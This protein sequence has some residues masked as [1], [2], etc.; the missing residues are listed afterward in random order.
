VLLPFILAI[1]LCGVFCLIPLTMYL[2]WLGAIT[3]RDRPTLVTGPWDFAGV[4]FAL[5]G[6]AIFGAGLVLSF[7]QA[8]FRFWMRGNFEALRGAWAQERGSWVLLVG[9][10]LVV[11]LSWAALVLAARRRSLVVYNIEPAALETL[12]TEVF[13]QLNRPLERR[14]K[15]WVGADPLFE[16][17]T[18]EGGHTATLRW[19][20]DDERLFEEV[21]RM[22]RTALASHASAENPADGWVRSA[23]YGCGMVVVCCLGLL[24]YGLTL[25]AR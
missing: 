3:R 22:L 6:F 16:L 19:V 24:V 15:L 4:L 12:L 17:D 1:C 14:G 23:A 25:M 7:A 20:S 2:L 5:S 18:F 10:Y 11:L 21:S 8:N 13:E 9:F